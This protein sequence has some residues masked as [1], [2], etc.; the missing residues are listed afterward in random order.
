MLSSHPVLAVPSGWAASNLPT[1]MQIVGDPMMMI[2]SFALA[3][4]EHATGGF[5]E[6][7]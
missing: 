7:L 2:W 5:D 3:L 6:R 1:G 4:R